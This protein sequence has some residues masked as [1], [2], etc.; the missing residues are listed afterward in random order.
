MRLFTNFKYT[1]KPEYQD[2]YEIDL[3]EENSYDAFN[4]VCYSTLVGMV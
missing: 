3:I 4:S 2:R 1:L